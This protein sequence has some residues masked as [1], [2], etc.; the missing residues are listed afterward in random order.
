MQKKLNTISLRSNDY[1]EKR[2]MEHNEN[3]LINKNIISAKKNKHSR[4]YFIFF[5][6]IL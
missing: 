6:I 5:K 1:R 4:V 2:R 3:H